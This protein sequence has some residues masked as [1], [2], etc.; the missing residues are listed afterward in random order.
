LLDD[1]GGGV[2]DG[3]GTRED[4]ED[5]VDAEDANRGITLVDVIEFVFV[6]VVSNDVDTVAVDVASGG[7]RQ[8]LGSIIDDELVSRTNERSMI[9]MPTA[10]SK[11]PNG[12]G[13]LTSEENK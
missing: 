9:D 10:I 8:R 2:D 6:V 1:G 12:S 7:S 13:K 4:D 3:G 5:V 11:N